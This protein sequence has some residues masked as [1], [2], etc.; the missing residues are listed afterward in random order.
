MKSM[1]LSEGALE[2]LNFANQQMFLLLEL[3]NDASD[4]S[5]IEN[6]QLKA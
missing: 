6:K 4:F 5:Q 2:T 3:L 1:N